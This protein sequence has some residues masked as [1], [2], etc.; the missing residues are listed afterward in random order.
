[1][2]IASIS[3]NLSLEKRIAITP[4]IVKKYI[5]NGFKIYLPKNYGV[6]LGIDDQQYKDLGVKILDNEN[7]ILKETDILVQVGLISDEKTSILRNN[8]TLIGSLDPYNNKDKLND[9]VKKKNKYFFI[10]IVT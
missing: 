8:Q 3:E 10:R 6:H 2:K 1:M 5:S 4:E 9:L 7:E